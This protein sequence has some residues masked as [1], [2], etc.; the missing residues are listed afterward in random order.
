[1]P[2]PRN[3]FRL[4]RTEQKII[5]L[6]VGGTIPWG[7]HAEG[8][9]RMCIN[10]AVEKYRLAEQLKSERVKSHG[11]TSLNKA[12]SGRS[13]DWDKKEYRR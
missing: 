1:M 8:F 11:P 6:Y 4:T 2:R 5:A 7:T 3:P 13:A 9:S 10:S 12:R